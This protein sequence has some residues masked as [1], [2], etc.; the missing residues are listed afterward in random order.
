MVTRDWL[1]QDEECMMVQGNDV[2]RNEECVMSGARMKCLRM[3]SGRS[4]QV[5]EIISGGGVLLVQWISVSG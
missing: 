2:L 3:R 5:D 4:F 1:S